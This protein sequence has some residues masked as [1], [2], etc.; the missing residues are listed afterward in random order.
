MTGCRSSV[1]VATAVLV[2][3]FLTIPWVAFAQDATITGTV[4]DATGGVLPGVTVTAVNDASGNTYETV[5]DERGVFRMPARIGTYRITATLAGF[6]DAGRPAVPVAVGQVVTIN[7]QMAP[8]GVQESLTVTGEAPLIEVST[9]SLGTNITEAQMQEL[10]V[11]GRNWQDLGML[12]VGN[13]VNDVSGPG[14][15]AVGVGTYQVNI[16]GQQITYYGGGLGNVQARISRDAIAQFEYISNRFDATQGR[17]SGV[18]INAVSKGGTNTPSGSVGAYFRSDKLNAQDPVLHETLPY[19]DQQL[20]FTFGGPIIRDKFHYFGNYEFEREPI[21]FVW[22]TPYPAFNMAFTG[23]RH[24]NKGGGR[25]DYQFSSSLSASFRTTIWKEFQPQDTDF[26]PEATRH[27]S[28]LTQVTRNANNELFTLTKVIGNRA[29]NEIR[30]GHAFVDNEEINRVHWENHPAKAGSGITNGSPIINFNGF[31][32]GPDGSIPQVIKQFNDSVR[33]DFTLTLNKAGRHDFKIGGEY[34]KNSWELMICRTCSGTYAAQAAGVALPNLQAVFPV[35]DNPDSWNYNAFNANITQYQLGIGNF[36]FAVDRHVFAGW[37]QD[38]WK[39]GQKLTLNL[40]LRYD[41]ALNAFGEKF[42]LE[43]WVEGNR[44]NDTDNIGPRVGFAYQLND[45]TVLRGGF[46]KYYSEVTD[47]SAHGTISWQKIVVLQVDNDGRPN[48]GSNPLNLAPGQPYPTFDQAVKLTC[49][50]QTV[51]QG[52]RK[53]GCIQ[54]SIN[55]NLASPG[56]HFPWA[57]QGSIGMQRQLSNSMAFEADYV[58][59]TSFD[60]ISARNPNLAYQP[61]GLPYN[62]RLV[63][64]LPYP[65]WGQISMRIN[66]RGR[67]GI[68]HT[69]QAGFTK[70]LSNHWQGSATYSYSRNYGIDQLPLNPGCSQPVSWN[71]DFTAWSCDTPGR[72]NFNSFNL[73]IYD[74]NWYRT[75]DQVNRVVFNGIFDLPYAFQLS[76]LYIYGD[77]GYATTTSGVD[78]LGVGGVVANRLRADLS[79]IPRNDFDKKDLHRVDLRFYRSFKLGRTSLQPMLEVFNLF[80][81]ANFTT[82]NLNESNARFGQPTATTGV[83]YAPRQIQLGFRATF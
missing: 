35:W 37:I 1:F 66:N 78:I 67:D 57:W 49:Y 38:D 33:D 61:N 39:L 24:D 62:V 50:D 30:A 59:S 9:S 17:S 52:G 82:W 20:S 4:T 6:A 74:R 77:N 7:L 58:Y 81:R 25:L 73:P 63:N 15:A 60:N 28:R 40:G 65:D 27:P 19:S 41:L 3:V 21:T 34:I 75:T 11:N 83:G 23:P 70:R 80:N 2:A 13:K 45:R 29:V 18:Q 71:A 51:N 54:R 46:G 68:S 8:S 64:R 14:I 79:I 22:D 55:N 5:T 48:F 36:N 26:P 72:V 69:V 43:P 56:S 10:P 16:D 31:T 47:M 44:P 32:V 76:G 53:P 42:A 12:A